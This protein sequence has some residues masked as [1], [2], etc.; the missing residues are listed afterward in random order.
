MARYKYEFWLNSDRE[1]DHEIAAI[2]ETLKMN[3]GFSAAIRNGLRLVADLNQD[4][5]DVL[6]E[7]YPDI[8]KQLITSFSGQNSNG[9]DDTLR[10]VLEALTS[11][12]SHS[13]PAPSPNYP[14]MKPSTNGLGITSALEV[15]QAAVDLDAMGDDFLAFIQ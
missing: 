9:S 11:L 6:L 12:Q 3:R 10:A 5:T 1:E 2:I 4:S 13:L 8:A 14:V 15:K 7:L